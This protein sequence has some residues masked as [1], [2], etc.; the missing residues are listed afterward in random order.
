MKKINLVAM[1]S[2][3]AFACQQNEVMDLPSGDQMVSEEIEFRE[4]PFGS[5][6]VNHFDPNARVESAYSL[7][8]HSVSYLTAPESNQMGKTIFFTDRGNKQLSDDFSPLVPWDGTASMDYFLDEARAP[9]SMNF[10]AAQAAIQRASSTWEGVNCSDLGLSQS[11]SFPLPLG[12]VALV[13]GYPSLGFPPS[14][15]NHLGWMPADFWEILAPG[16]SEFILGAT[17]TLT[18]ID[19]EGQPLDTNQDG[20]ADV[21][22]REIYYNDYFTWV[23]GVNL[24]G[25]IDVETV[26]LHEMGHGLS[27]AHFGEAFRTPSGKLQFAP[28]AVMNAAYSGIQTR[29]GGTDLAGHCSIW[30]NWPNR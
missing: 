18:Y 5:I 28:R 4:N 17:F 7:V 27:Q 24:P 15:V 30:G 1:F 10:S 20:K 21:A 14:E 22:F 23:D 29:I 19:E 6:P 9:S 11:S 8:L 26:A 25:T 16:G 2:M 3:L 13:F 12:F